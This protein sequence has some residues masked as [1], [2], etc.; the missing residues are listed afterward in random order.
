VIGSQVLKAIRRLTMHIR[1]VEQ[2]FAGIE[3][4]LIVNA[5]I[6]RLGLRGLIDVCADCAVS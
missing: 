4:Q 2:D 1:A 3:T 5:F 6:G